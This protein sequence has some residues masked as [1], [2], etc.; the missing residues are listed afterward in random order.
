MDKKGQGISMTY[1]IIAALALV[2]LVVIILFFTGG[3]GSLFG[4]QKDATEGA[5]EQQKE[6]WRGQCK[7]YCTLG[8]KE[9]WCKHI[10]KDS[11]DSEGKWM[12]YVCND[13]SKSYVSTNIGSLLTSE[14]QSSMDSDITALEAECADIE[15]C[16]FGTTEEP[17]VDI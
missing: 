9:N 6:I 8:Q 14:E 17:R 12:A 2:V 16:E 3:I 15:N 13:D 11:K 4:Q 7:L 1:I 5:T 10:F